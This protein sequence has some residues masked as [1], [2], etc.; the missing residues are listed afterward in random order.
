MPGVEWGRRYRAELR[1]DA[2]AVAGTFLTDFQRRLDDGLGDALA[3]EVEMVESMLVRTKIIE[4]SSRKSSEHKMR[5]LVEFMHEELST[6]MVR[7]LIVCAD[8]LCRGGQSRLSKKLNSVR[9]GPDP[10]GVLRNCAWDLFLP[11][12]LDMLAGAKPVE[13]MDFYLPHIITFDGDVKD[14]V[15]LTEL[16]SIALHRPSG[17]VLPFFNLDPFSWISERLGEKRADELHPLF[18]EAAYA[19]RSARRSRESIRARLASDREVLR[20]IISQ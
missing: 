18:Q 6:I 16:R 14:I 17:T 20:A 11:R 2:E 5:E 15:T 3:G 10:F 9:N 19:A 13:G 8:I 7:E 12:A 1:E 4:Y